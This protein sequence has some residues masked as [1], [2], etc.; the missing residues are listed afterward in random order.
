MLVCL[1][2]QLQESVCNTCILCRPRI[3]TIRPHY[4]IQL[5]V[6]PPIYGVERHS[7]QST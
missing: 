2:N 3:R 6:S 4:H 5:S 7:E 1:L